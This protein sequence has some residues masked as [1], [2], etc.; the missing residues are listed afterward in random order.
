VGESGLGD[1]LFWEGRHL[2]HCN[3]LLDQY[4]QGNMRLFL[5]R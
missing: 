5:S 2:E 4:G 1:V 3:L